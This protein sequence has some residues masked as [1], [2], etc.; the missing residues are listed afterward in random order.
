M[1]Y[2]ICYIWWRHSDHKRNAWLDQELELLQNRMN[3][4]F[5]GKRKRKNQQTKKKTKKSTNKKQ[6]KEKQ[7]HHKKA[8][9]K[10]ENTKTEN[11]R[12]DL[13]KNTNS[14]KP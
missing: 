14:K 5:G 1:R 11:R 2:N 7:K 4:Q 8:T 13:R 6:Y 9:I 12:T 10:T 3:V